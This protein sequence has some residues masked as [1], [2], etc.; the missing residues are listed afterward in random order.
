M[1]SVSCPDPVVK[2]LPMYYRYLKKLESEG[3]AFITSTALAEMT[4]LTASQVRQDV[5]TFGGAGR[6]GSGYPVAEMRQYIA[7]I[8]GIDKQQTMVIVGMGNL[9]RAIAGYEPFSQNHFETV[10]AFDA[11]PEK[12]GKRVGQ[13]IIRHV[14]EMEAF[15][16]EHRVDIA[17]LTLPAAEAQAISSRL[18]ECGVRGFWNFAPVDLQLPRNAAIVNVHLDASLERLSYR[19]AHP[20]LW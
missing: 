5:N 12:A 11:D 6:Q 8:L 9:G 20:D 17:V 2:R 16:A 10:A 4:G 15:L 1:M 13:L 19:L 3:T 14:E 7:Q 18:Y